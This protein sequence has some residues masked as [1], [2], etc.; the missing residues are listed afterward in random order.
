MVVTAIDPFGA[1]D[2]IDV[3]I[4]VTDEDDPPVITVK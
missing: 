2:S 4:N 3:T 1:I